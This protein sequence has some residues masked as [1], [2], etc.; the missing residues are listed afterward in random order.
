MEPVPMSEVTLRI[1]A[2][3]LLKLPESASYHA[4]SGRAN[5][6]VKTDGSQIIVH[7][8]CDSLQRLCEYYES[9][10]GI[11]RKGYEELQSSIQ[12]ENERRSN[13]VKIAITAFIAGL[14]TGIVSIFIKRKRK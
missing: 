13:P 11:Y 12:T 2:D 10:A 14:A 5:V 6:D 8:S 3:S 4:K 1:P 9:V 7:A